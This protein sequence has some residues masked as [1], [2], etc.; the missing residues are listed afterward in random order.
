MLHIGGS[1]RAVRSQVAFQPAVVVEDSA[2]LGSGLRRVADSVGVVV[3][4]IADPPGR[5]TR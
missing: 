2:T 3:S 4:G 1:V 5:G